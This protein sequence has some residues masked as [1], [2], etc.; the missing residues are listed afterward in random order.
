MASVGRA[1]GALLDDLQKMSRDEL[2]AARRKKFLGM[3]AKGLA[4]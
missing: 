2:I 4:A 1:I 3:G